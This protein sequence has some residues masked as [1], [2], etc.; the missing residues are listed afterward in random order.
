MF[1]YFYDGDTINWGEGID[2]DFNTVHFYDYSQGDV[3]QWNW[4]FGDGTTSN[5]Q[6]PTHVYEGADHEYW[7]TLAIETRDSCYSTAENIVYIGEW[8]E[9]D[10]TVYITMSD[11]IYADPI[12]ACF[13]NYSIP[14]DSVF[15]MDFEILEDNILAVNWIFWQAGESY[16][17]PVNYNY[18]EEGLNVINLTILC[19]EDGKG[20]RST[21]VTD[22]INIKSGTGIN[23][24]ELQKFDVEMYPNPVVDKLY[25]DFDSEEKGT[26][27][28]RIYN[29]T[30]YEVLYQLSDYQMGNNQIIID[31]EKLMKGVYMIDLSLDNKFITARKFVK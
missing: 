30:G 12:Y 14:I 19:D 1:F 29:L 6:H 17:L 10:S 16:I 13:I 20:L 25:L 18:V 27:T 31:T 24:P 28:T 5:E 7:V 23:S 3:I 4:D 11:T 2:Y 9:N 8:W 22:V 26:L 15:V 21:T